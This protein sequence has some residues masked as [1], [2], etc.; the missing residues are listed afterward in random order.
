MKKDELK[1]VL[2][3]TPITELFEVLQEIMDEWLKATLIVISEIFDK[4]FK[5]EIN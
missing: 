1:E 5:D 4:E 3:E 2:Q